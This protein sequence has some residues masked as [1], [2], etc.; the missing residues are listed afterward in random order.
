MATAMEGDEEDPERQVMGCVAVPR[1]ELRGVTPSWTAGPP[2]PREAFSL[3]HTYMGGS[4]LR[5]D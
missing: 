2:G 5:H 1:D 4:W 3:W